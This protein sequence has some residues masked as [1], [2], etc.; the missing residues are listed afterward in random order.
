MAGTE[1]LC[2]SFQI[3]RAS[4][5]SE[6]KLGEFSQSQSEAL[7]FLKSQHQES[8]DEFLLPMTTNK[9]NFDSFSNIY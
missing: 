4:V 5:S 8:A 9:V 1:S 3:H 7:A 2:D 6:E